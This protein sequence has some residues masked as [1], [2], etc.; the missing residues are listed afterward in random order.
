MLNNLQLKWILISLSL[1]TPISR[2]EL[3]RVIY[4]LYIV[5][6]VVTFLNMRFD[7]Y[8]ECESIFGSLFTSH[9][10]MLLDDVS[11]RNSC[12]HFKNAL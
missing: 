7:K 1:L 6:Q 12:V 4:F 9:K 8:K 10:F 11:L 5:Y 2:E 3:F